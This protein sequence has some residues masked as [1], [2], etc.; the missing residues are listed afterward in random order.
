MNKRLEAIKEYIERADYHSLELDGIEISMTN[1]HGVEVHR[2][3]TADSAL[4]DFL[5]NGVQDMKYLINEVERLRQFENMFAEVNGISN[6][7]LKS[8]FQIIEENK[9]LREALKFYADVENYEW[10]E[11]N[12]LETMPGDVLSDNGKTARQ[13]LNNE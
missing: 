7:T 12:D 13:V 2:F 8:A 10:H 9:R 6:E 4:D 5:L 1:S 3:N 11:I